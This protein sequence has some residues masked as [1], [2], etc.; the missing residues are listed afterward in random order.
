MK[1]I[2]FKVLMSGE[3]VVCEDTKTVQTIDGIQYLQ[4]HRPGQ[5]RTF[6][7][8]KDALAKVSVDR[9]ARVL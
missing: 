9:S 8:R 3:L 1:P 2:N 4:V 7:M 6:L 5:D